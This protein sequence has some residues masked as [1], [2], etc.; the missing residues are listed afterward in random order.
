LRL[1]AVAAALLAAFATA[2]RADDDA[3]V[4]PASCTPVGQ[5][6]LAQ[7]HD[8]LK[9]LLHGHDAEHATKA[10]H[11][12]H[13]ADSAL[14]IGWLERSLGAKP[15]AAFARA[16]EA[17]CT[18]V[19][20]ALEKTL[21]DKEAAVW[22]LVAAAEVDAPPSLDQSPYDVESVWETAELR[23]LA[24]AL[25][26]APAAL[27]HVPSLRAIRRLPSGAHAKKGTFYN[28][29]SYKKDLELHQLGTIV[30]RDTVWKFA[31]RDVRAVVQHELGHHW[32]FSR[33][34]ETGK[35]WTALQEPWLQL[36]GWR[37]K[38]G[39]HEKND[40]ELPPG[41]QIA[42][43]GETIPSEDF[44]DSIANHRFAPRLMKAYS[45]EKLEVMDQLF[46][47]E[48]KRPLPEL[49]AAWAA[50]GGPLKS[51]LECAAQIQRATFGPKHHQHE[52][53]VVITKAKGTHWE[54][55]AR[56]QFVQKGGCIDRAMAALQASP[57]WSEVTCNHDPENVAVAVADRLEEVWAAFSE[58][59][60][61]IRAAVPAETAAGCLDKKNLTSA[62]LAGER[63]Q[64][65]AH[66]E[67]ERIA[68]EFHGEDAPALVPTL[69]AQT[70]LLP[71]DDEVL[72]RFP[73]LKA[74][75]D[76][77]FACLKST[78]EIKQGKGGGWLYW[79]K[80]P[81]ESETRSFGSPL[82]NPS[83][84]HAFAEHLASHAGLTMDAREK[85]FIHFA[86]L[87]RNQA[88]PVVGKFN[89]A[90]LGDVSGLRRSCKNKDACAS[91][92]KQKLQGVLPDP[93]ADE[94]ATA[95]S[96][97]LH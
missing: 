77:V 62:C 73:A 25:L 15:P 89:Q 40:Y 87:L 34:R 42:T 81:A 93:Q 19:L 63:G 68:A 20:C 44:C 12:L 58:S 35:P 11:G 64:E 32:E 51:L 3:L 23:A 14:A 13:L 41:A 95:L 24:R 47:A 26:D 28:A 38:N 53:Y 66:K 39:G 54:P 27:K 5:Q 52:L 18:T 45:K 94:L 48:P 90:V 10:V 76:L 37:S 84:E 56:N 49:D 33:S 6:R 50:I 21:G 9:A 46:G 59:A 65:V 91:W 61:A 85:L 43:A 1:A 97:R 92:L 36:S 31:Q 4:L 69:I 55:V 78:V 74:A 70:P 7:A 71:A 8:A 88:A 86:Y 29:V 82:W 17:G 83:C 2:A 16:V 67:A 30:I 72:E 57:K 79:V 96:S 80:L 60:A 22:F 75:D